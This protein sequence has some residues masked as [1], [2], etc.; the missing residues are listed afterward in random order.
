MKKW[1]A[2][3]LALVMTVG[4]CACGGKKLDPAAV[5]HLY[6]VTVTINPQLTLYM[7][8]NDQVVSVAFD[9][10][11]AKE[12][13]ASISFVGLDLETAIETAV[14]TAVDNGRLHE[15]GLL[16]IRIA[17]DSSEKTV[18]TAALVQR[19]EKKAETLLEER[20]IT[21]T[22]VVNTAEN[23][24]TVTTTTT[25]TAETT[26]TTEATTT[27]TTTAPTTTTTTTT[28]KPLTAADLYGTYVGY[29]L[30]GD[31]A[32]QLKLTLTKDNAEYNY[33][34]GSTLA[35]VLKE[36]GN[37]F[38]TEEAAL[39]D[40]KAN[41]DNWFQCDGV[42]Y[43]ARL[44]DGDGGAVKAFTTTALTL[45]TGATLQMHYDRAKSTLTITG[46]NFVFDKKFYQVAL[47]KQ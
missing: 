9:N 7:D 26:T 8:E 19:A 21:A 4:L 36:E 12:D 24:T 6:A 1:I 30:D 13:Y 40:I 42:W 3:A 14:S 45:E 46:G 20:K 31:R 22:V 38:G 47:K 37:P 32:Y 43:Q 28:Q 16:D 25:T 2:L 11:D 29:R 15:G 41:P 39:A 44:G 35:A 27:T 23:G 17:D 5:S 10:E 34:G 18:D 33:T